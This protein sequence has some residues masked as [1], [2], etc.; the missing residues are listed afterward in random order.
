MVESWEMG[1]DKN[2]TPHKRAV[3]TECIERRKE[4]TRQ[5]H[6]SPSAI[7]A[8]LQ[9]TGDSDSNS[10]LPPHLLSHIIARD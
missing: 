5:R 10:C 9:L 6:A 1:K 3:T 8:Y 2:N 7:A 4:P